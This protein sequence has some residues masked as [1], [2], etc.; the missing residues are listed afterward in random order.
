MDFTLLYNS[1]N[2]WLPSRFRCRNHMNYQ[3]A[4][5]SFSNI[6]LLFSSSREYQQY[7][8]LVNKIDW[9]FG[10]IT[11]SSTVYMYCNKEIDVPKQLDFRKTPEYL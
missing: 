8:L 3:L 4:H 10:K 2:Q 1:Y 11:Q 7:L 9:F 5:F 6:F